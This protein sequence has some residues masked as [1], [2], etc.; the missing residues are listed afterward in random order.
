M[1]HGIP[2]L[3][4]PNVCD[5]QR[6]LG[7]P[8]ILFHTSHGQEEKE[9]ASGVI[10]K[11]W[12]QKMSLF[13]RFSG[14]FCAKQCLWP[15]YVRAGHSLANYLTLPILPWMAR[16]LRHSALVCANANDGIWPLLIGHKPFCQPHT[17]LWAVCVSTA[18]LFANR[19]RDSRGSHSFGP[20]VFRWA[21][22]FLVLNPT[23]SIRKA[24]EMIMLALLG[25][26]AV[27]AM[28]GQQMPE[29]GQQVALWF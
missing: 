8:S 6:I 20:L 13:S 2:W 16:L 1:A 19:R 18:P 10:Q 15:S 4:T 22:S 26:F 28:A 29:F 25:L 5:D 14:K 17:S 21:V 7:T 27:G 3:F 23:I 24:K 12:P 9:R 11:A